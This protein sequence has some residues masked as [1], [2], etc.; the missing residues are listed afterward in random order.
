MYHRYLP[1][2]GGDEYRWAGA[3]EPV[4]DMNDIRS[5]PTDGAIDF[6]K[7]NRIEKEEKELKRGEFLVVE[8]KG[9]DSASGLFHQ[10]HFVLIHDVFPSP[11]YIVGMYI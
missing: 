6:N 5:E 3:K 8:K 11:L 1:P 7:R 10:F 9:A 2:P 4:M